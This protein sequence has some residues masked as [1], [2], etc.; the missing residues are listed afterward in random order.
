MQ[1]SR[2][3]LSITNGPAL[4]RLIQNDNNEVEFKE[5]IILTK[6]KG[7]R[8]VNIDHTPEAYQEY[9]TTQKFVIIVE[10]TQNYL[11]K[12]FRD[13]ENMPLSCVVKIFNYKDW[14]KSFHSNKKWG[15]TEVSML[16][17]F[18]VEHSFISEEEK[19]KAIRHWP[20][21]RNRVTKL[22]HETSYDVY[23][24]LMKE[25]DTDMKGMLLLLEIMMTYSAS[26]SACERRFSSM[27]RQKTSLRTLMTHQTLDDVMRIC[28]DGGNLQAFDPTPHYTIWLEQTKGTRHVY[29]NKKK[30][31]LFAEV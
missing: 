4:D 10:G 25:N 13:F 15:L 14:P 29:G 12:R 17:T 23:R 22:R 28:V 27:N 19:D 8:D 18:Y 11:R 5:D 30:R 26:T 24:D 20:I 31:I 1:Q 9:F 3:C 6:P 21:F 2:V 7:R 16:G